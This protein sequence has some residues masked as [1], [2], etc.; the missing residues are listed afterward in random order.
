MLLFFLFFMKTHEVGYPISRTPIHSNFTRI[1]INQLQLI[2][3]H[4][5]YKLFQYP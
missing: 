2:A 1:K 4:A 3:F 5:E